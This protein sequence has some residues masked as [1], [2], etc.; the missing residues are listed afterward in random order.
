MSEISI[1]VKLGD[2]TYP[3]TVGRDEEER[4]RKA[5]KAVNDN[6]AKLKDSYGV[7][8]AKDLL[9][10]TSLEFASKYMEEVENT[11]KDHDLTHK[12]RK[13]EEKLEHYLGE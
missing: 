3:L 4:I 7:S 1:N 11:S 5:A 8:D 6:I 12:I 13:F 2:R 9:A 10:M